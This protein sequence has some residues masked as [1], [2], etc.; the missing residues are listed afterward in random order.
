MKKLFILLFALVLGA[1][2]MMAQDVVYLKNGS[3]IKGSVLEIVP[4]QSI[5]IQTSD[6]SIFVYQMSEV[7]RIQQDAK[8]T[9]KQQT[10]TEDEPENYLKRGFRG[11]VDLGAH[12][13]FGDGEDNYQISAAFTGGYQINRMLFVGAGV[14]PT[15]NLF[16]YETYYQKE[17]TE[18]ATSFL[19]P[20]YSA[21]R[22][23]FINKK[24]TPFLDGRIGYFINTKDVDYS[25]LYAYLGVGVRLKKISLSAGY[26]I[27]SN[28]N[29]T[30]GFATVR[31]GFEF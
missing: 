15:L 13:G 26:D 1:T 30:P 3:I 10:Y 21:I 6:G 29:A 8:N 5:K 4:N 23:D 28:D 12:V 18:I 16:E 9:Q 31:F 17:D 27:Y 22:L 2:T 20:I 11:L 7:D 14:A 25:G 19:L 24:V